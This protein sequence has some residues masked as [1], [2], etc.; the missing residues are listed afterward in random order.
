VRISSSVL[1]M[2]VIVGLVATGCGDKKSPT[3]PSEPRPQSGVL[4]IS[5]LSVSAYGPPGDITYLL[6]MRMSETTGQAAVTIN[7]LTVAFEDG[8]RVTVPIDDARLN[9]GASER[10]NNA[11]FKDET[12]TPATTR[13]T[14]TMGYRAD[15]GPGGSATA[16]A[17]V[18]MLTLVTLSGV[19]TNRTTRAPI[20]GAKVEVSSLSGP[21]AGKETTADGAG[22]YA[23]RVVAGAFN[24]RVTAGGYTGQSFPIDVATD[25]PFDIALSPT[26]PPAAAVEYSI[27]G[28]AKTCQATYRSSSGGTSQA[29]VTIPWSFTR[30]ATTGDFLY[31]SC[32]IDSSGDSGSIFVRISRHGST[33]A[34]AS[35]TGFPHIAT[36]DAVY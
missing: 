14:I 1:A 22:R 13:L 9:A 3:A 28:S 31:V 24:I 6:S 20:A 23:L 17:S 12:G 36:A 33:V 15:V 35:A 25:A 30:S 8:R 16:S 5:E 29:R 2:L 7:S 10:L 26:P 4:S 19:V 34:S 11:S 32:Q 27:T 21:N 18:Q